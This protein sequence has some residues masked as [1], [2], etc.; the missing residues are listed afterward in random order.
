MTPK[1]KWKALGWRHT[2]WDLVRFYLSLA[3]RKKEQAA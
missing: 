2:V 1:D 3:R